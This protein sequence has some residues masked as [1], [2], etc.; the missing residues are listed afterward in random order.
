[1]KINSNVVTGQ[2]TQGHLHHRQNHIANAKVARALNSSQGTLE[3]ST[4]VLQSVIDLKP[5]LYVNKKPV[6]DTSRNTIQSMIT[7]DGIGSIDK[8]ERKRFLDKKLSLPV[9][10]MNLAS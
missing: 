8:E 6:M 5:K 1:M 3:D 4:P 10:G 2:P 7:I 9:D